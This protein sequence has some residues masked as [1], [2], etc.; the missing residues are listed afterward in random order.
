MTPLQLH[1]LR[2]GATEPNLAGLRCGGDL[3]VP[4]TDVGRRQAAQ[5]ALRIQELR[6]GVGV[7]V[8]SRLV[9]TRET[10]QIVSRV[11]HGVEV[12]V[13]PGF[14]ERRLGQWNLRPVAETQAALAQGVTPPGG[15]SN[16]E[17]VQRVHAALEALAPRL[18]QQ[19][20]L[21]GSRGI[22]RV[23]RE[24]VNQGEP[25]GRQDVGNGQLAH[26]DLSRFAARHASRLLE[27]TQA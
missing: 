11:L 5:A 23:L 22:A 21:V 8:T 17:F 18:T 27:T 16:L 10:A 6:L 3:D 26:F 25:G 14:A 1:F 24:L 9:R 2:H 12:I 15:E 7:I 13:E 19:P 4:L 20:L